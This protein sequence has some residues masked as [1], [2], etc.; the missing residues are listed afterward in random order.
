[1]APQ[2]DFLESL[3]IVVSRDVGNVGTDNLLKTKRRQGLD[4]MHSLVAGRV[5]VGK[6]STLEVDRSR[7]YCSQDISA[8]SERVYTEVILKKP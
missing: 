5:S 8:S 7:T 3:N 4:G 2:E 1:M 6:H